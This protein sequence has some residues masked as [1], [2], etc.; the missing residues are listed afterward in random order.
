MTKTQADTGKV[1]KEMTAECSQP[2]N[3]LCAHINAQVH[4][5]RSCWCSTLSRKP[6]MENCY[7]LTVMVF[8]LMAGNIIIQ[9]S[10]FK[11]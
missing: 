9:M 2:W 6:E 4:D 3:V 11:E 1:A 7:H 5:G 8:C 10:A